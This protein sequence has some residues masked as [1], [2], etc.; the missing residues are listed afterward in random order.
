MQDKIMTSIES[1]PYFYIQTGADRAYYACSDSVVYYFPSNS[2][3]I[4]VSPNRLS[5]FIDFIDRKLKD[6]QNPYGA[7]MHTSMYQGGS[8]IV[9]HNNIRYYSLQALQD[10]FN[11]KNINISLINK[12]DLKEKT[13][14]ELERI[15]H[16]VQKEKEKRNEKSCCS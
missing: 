2:G 9:S 4:E 11:I 1:E 3:Y 10:Y 5:S 12:D 14:R 15:L 7:A 6:M 8:G 16:V 13:I